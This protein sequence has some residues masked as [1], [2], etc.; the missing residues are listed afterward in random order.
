MPSISTGYLVTLAV[1]PVLLATSSGG[2]QQHRSD[3]PQVSSSAPAASAIPLAEPEAGGTSGESCT[4][5]AD[6]RTG[7]KCQ[8]QV[9]IDPTLGVEGDTCA[10]TADCNA[11]LRCITNRCAKPGTAPPAPV[12]SGSS[13]KPPSLAEASARSDLAD[14]Q[15]QIDEHVSESVWRPYRGLASTLSV[16]YGGVTTGNGLQGISYGFNGALPLGRMVGMATLLAAGSGDTDSFGAYMVGLR[17]GHK[18]FFDALFGWCKSR[19]DDTTT[20]GYT[21]PEVTYDVHAGFGVGGLFGF[22]I[23]LNRNFPIQWAI[24]PQVAAAYPFGAKSPVVMGLAGISLVVP[25]KEE[26]TKAGR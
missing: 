10:K 18:V 19:F 25:Q 5:A 24:T 22:H 9:C 13:G 21:S 7:L 2:A 6:C 17:L 11:H 16:G 15:A 14:N 12:A 3:P 23:N 20:Y 26:S 1:I 8:N 4:R